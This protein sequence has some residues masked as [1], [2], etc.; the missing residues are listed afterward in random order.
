MICDY[1]E[2]KT[3]YKAKCLALA[4]TIYSE[5]GVHNKA[6]LCLCK[7]GQVH[8]AMEYIQQFTAF[9]ASKYKRLLIYIHLNSGL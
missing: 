8:A 5:C 6:L 2:K 4:Q 7:Q 9:T 1:G 3:Y